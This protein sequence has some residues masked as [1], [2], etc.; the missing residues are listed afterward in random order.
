MHMCV[1]QREMPLRFNGSCSI[2]KNIG[3]SVIHIVK[4]ASFDQKSQALYSNIV[5]KFHSI[6]LIR[7]SLNLMNRAGAPILLFHFVLLDLHFSETELSEI[8][9]FAFIFYLFLFRYS[10]EGIPGLV[11]LELILFLRHTTFYSY[12]SCSLCCFYDSLKFTKFNL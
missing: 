1:P 11:A 10:E 3:Q 5:L 2:V 6:L 7:W 4:S 9:L 8:V 12:I